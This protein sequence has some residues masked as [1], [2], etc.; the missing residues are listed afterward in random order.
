MSTGRGGPQ[1]IYSGQISFAP[2]YQPS[3]GLAATPPRLPALDPGFIAKVE[4]IGP[5]YD[6]QPPRSQD[7]P[8]GFFSPPDQRNALITRSVSFFFRFR[9]GVLQEVPQNDAARQQGEFYAAATVFSQARRT[10]H[11][12]TVPFDARTG[13]VSET[14]YDWRCLSFRHEPAQNGGTYAFLAFIGEEEGLPAVV[15]AWEKLIPQPYRYQKTY[16][17]GN[18]IPP[19]TTCAGLIG[20][21]PLLLALAA[22]SARPDALIPALRESRLATGR[23]VPHNYTTGVQERGLVVTIYK[24]PGNTA[25]S[26]DAVLQNLEKGV[27]GAFYAP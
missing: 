10:D 23:W 14:D 1:S 22:F 21:L 8:R 16:E 6:N 2:S 13:N 12:L 5:N 26:T 25:G 27:Y 7:D 9:G 4:E 19:G 15:P 20:S 11:L 3:G 24:D 17:N 18:P